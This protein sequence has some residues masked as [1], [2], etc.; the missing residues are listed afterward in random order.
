MNTNIKLT[1]HKWSKEDIR[2]V[3]TTCLSTPN[4]KDRMSVLRS[5]F[6]D[7]SDGSLGYQIIRY[8]KRNDNTTHWDP[9]KNIYEGY[10]SNGRLHSEVWNEKDWR[11]TSC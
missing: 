7:C 4:K 10:G 5:H 9:S 8:Q 1:H 3:F 6:P 2:K 11:Q